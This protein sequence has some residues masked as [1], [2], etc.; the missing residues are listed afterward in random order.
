MYRAF[1]QHKPLRRT[2]R[3]LV[4]LILVSLG[5][6]HTAMAVP[7]YRLQLLLTLGGPFTSPVSINN[8]EEIAGYAFAANEPYVGFYAAGVNSIAQIGH[9]GTYASAINASGVVVGDNNVRAFAWHNGSY[10]DLGPGY[11]VGINDSGTIVGY[12]VYGIATIW[13]G[14]NIEVLGVP[15]PGQYSHA[16]GINNAGQVVAMITYPDSR[17]FMALWSSGSWSVTSLQVGSGALAINEAGQVVGSTGSSTV[18]STG[19]A[20]LWDN[21]LLRDLGTLLPGGSGAYDVNN[22][23]QVVGNSYSFGEFGRTV[24]FL[25]DQGVMYDLNTLLDATGVGWNVF[26]AQ[27][28]NDLG[29]IVGTAYHPSHGHRGVLLTPTTIPEPMVAFATFTAKLELKLAPRIDDTFDLE[30]RFTLGTG[31]N[32]IDPQTE[33]V[34]L[35]L[36]HS[37]PDTFLSHF[38]INS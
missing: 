3:L 1:V 5:V 35:E 20:F 31:S 16:M 28:I 26:T 14:G 4:L 2:F 38:E 15:A 27:G 6:V 25:W 23:S 19:H 34:T 22:L 9:T 24:A 18:G 32:G 10:T 21:G 17:R 37:L 8:T 11:A 33:D 13:Q 29:Q 12:N 30:S 36:K 7:S